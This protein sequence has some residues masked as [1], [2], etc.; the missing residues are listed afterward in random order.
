MGC[1]EVPEYRN[2]SIATKHDVETSTNE[3]RNHRCIRKALP[4][5]KACICTW[6][7]RCAGVFK[8][9]LILINQF[10]RIVG[11]IPIY[12]R[13]LSPQQLELQT[14]N[15]VSNDIS[16]LQNI[17]K[18]LLSSLFKMQSHL[19]IFSD[20]LMKMNSRKSFSRMMRFLN[21]HKSKRMKTRI[22][23]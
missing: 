2:P 10:L 19:R 22:K 21:L 9:G 17:I 1:I 5:E 18:L 7:S 12:S 16:S 15:D 13:I 6:C 20:L 14:L 11:N 4:S 23:S 8:C 3:C